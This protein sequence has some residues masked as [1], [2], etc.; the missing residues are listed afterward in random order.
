MSATRRV[1]IAEDDDYVRSALDNHFTACGFEVTTATNYCD[2]KDLLD[3]NL[4]DLIVSD[5]GMPLSPGSA[6]VDRTCGLQ[7]LGY[8][9]M[10]EQHKHI[11]F[12][13]HTADDS[14]E[15]KRLAKE[16]GGVYRMKND[17]GRSIVDFCEQLLKQKE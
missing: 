17:P 8:A 11:P 2:V 5:N 14:E 12:V 1:L 4:Y 15:T 13:L 7:L 9:Q 3:A 10:C 6:R 16:L